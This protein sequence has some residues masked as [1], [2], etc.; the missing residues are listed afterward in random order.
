MARNRI[1]TA[2]Y[3][4]F[5]V[6]LVLLLSGQAA[7]ARDHSVG[8]AAHRPDHTPDIEGSIAREAEAL[9]AAQTVT[10]GTG[11]NPYLM[12][13][14]AMMAGG[15]ILAV[16]GF[17]NYDACAGLSFSCNERN[18]VYFGLTGAGVAAVGAYLFYRGQQL[19]DSRFVID[20]APRSVNV[21][22]RVGR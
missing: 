19:K 22:M 11:T 4:T 18:S 10:P 7:L 13:A 8:E 6:C 21:R 14:I 20:L 9:A 1:R 16:W 3:R 2:V 12:P 5:S 15:G 17:R